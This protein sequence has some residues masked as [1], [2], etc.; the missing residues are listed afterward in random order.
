M[1]MNIYTK[2]DKFGAYYFTVTLDIMKHNVFS[3]II[4]LFMIK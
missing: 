1:N 4:I 3:N 2:T